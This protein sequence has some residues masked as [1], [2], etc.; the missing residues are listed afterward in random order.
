MLPGKEKR[1][2]SK[3]SVLLLCCCCY[4]CLWLSCSSKYSGR[5]GRDEGILEKDRT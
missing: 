5:K 4:T 1:P 3:L 2:P